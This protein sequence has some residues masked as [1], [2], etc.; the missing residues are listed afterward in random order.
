MPQE[1]YYFYT[2][3]K[4][5]NKEDIWSLVPE[6]AVLVYENTNTVKAWNDVQK[7]AIWQNLL[8]IP[9]YK[10]LK[11]DFESLDSIGGKSGQLDLLLR[12]NPLLMSM[13]VTGK[14]NFGFVFFLEL[15]N[16]ESN[17]I[18]R[19]IISSIKENSENTLS[20]RVYKKFEINEIKTKKTGKVIR[21]HIP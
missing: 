2:Q 19:K 7:K 3:F 8:T 18:A 6:N 17:E 5:A 10:D 11:T 13:H 1:G 9:F 12:G 21:L 14:D 4:N 20:K 16:L 15:P